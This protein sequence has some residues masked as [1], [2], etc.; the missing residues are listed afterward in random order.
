MASGQKVNSQTRKSQVQYDQEQLTFP[1]SDTTML[2]FS[3][4]DRIAQAGAANVVFDVIVDGFC[5][6]LRT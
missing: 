5:N 3:F 4:R 1:G 6:A 2:G